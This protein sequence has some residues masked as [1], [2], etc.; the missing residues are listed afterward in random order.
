[1]KLRETKQVSYEELMGKLPDCVNRP[2]KTRM[3][4][5]FSELDNESIESEEHPDHVKCD[6]L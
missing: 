6:S 2:L 4:E 3:N 5:L 1:M